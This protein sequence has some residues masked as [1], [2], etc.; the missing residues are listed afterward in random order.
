MSSLDAQTHGARPK[1]KRLLVSQLK[2]L[3]IKAK[4]IPP[5]QTSQQQHLLNVGNVPPNTAASARAERDERS[6]RVLGLLR[7]PP[8][9]HVPLRLGEERRVPVGRVN[10][11][12]DD[13][14]SRDPVAVDLVA[15]RRRDA[16]EPRADG[17]EQ[18]QG[19]VESG[20]QV[21]QVLDAGVGCDA[22]GVYGGVE[23]DLLPEPFEN[24]WVL[25]EKVHDVG[26][27]YRRGV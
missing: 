2:P 26:Q 8:F 10:G 14:A 22:V 18:A 23:V 7:Q 24:A 1:I 20:A 15:L 6:L 4:V 11:D 21:G 12:R 19:L 5:H 27:G 9:G 25:E 16:V 17:R 13:G 3:I